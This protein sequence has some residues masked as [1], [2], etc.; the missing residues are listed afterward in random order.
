MKK[1]V[2]LVLAMVM[3]LGLATTA[4]AADVT[5]VD[6][7]FTNQFEGFD[8]KLELADAADDEEFA[9]YEIVLYAK[10]TGA[11]F[12]GK[13]YDKGDDVTVDGEW[14]IVPSAVN[15]EYA[16]VD[17]KKVTYLADAEDFEDGWAEKA[18]M[19]KLEWVADPSKWDCN[20]YYAKSPADDIYFLYDGVFYVET[21]GIAA[22][23]YIFNVD[24]MAVAAN[25]A[26]VMN[27]LDVA[28]DTD[29]ADFDFYFNPH[30]YQFTEVWGKNGNELEKVYCLC[31]GVKTYFDF[32]NAPESVAIN[33]F[34]R[35]GYAQVGEYDGLPVYVKDVAPT[36]YNV[37]AGGASVG[38][39][40]SADGET[41]TSPKTFDAGIAMYVGM[42]VMAAAGSAV[43]LKKKD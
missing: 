37:I 33:T 3:V 1:I 4:F 43:V 11:E 8:A 2:A 41:V 31:D 18:K 20:A 17:G 27:T 39:A 9:T 35:Y 22:A 16:V 6:G 38:T 36:N 26:V 12:G 15:A 24:G 14:V 7:A 30:V 28:S 21:T 23:D 40:G 13:E 29:L 19:V 32:V 42:S 25:K 34:G 5:S 10:K